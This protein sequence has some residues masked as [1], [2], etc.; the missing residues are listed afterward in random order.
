MGLGGRRRCRRGRLELT[1]GLE[2]SPQQRGALL[3]AHAAEYID[4][5][6]SFGSRGKSMTLP[7]APAF[8]SQAPNTTRDTRALSTAPMHI[9]HGSSVAYSVV[10]P[11]R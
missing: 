6:L 3:A 4:T 8:W 5:M 7:Q 9:A 2:E 10:P 1:A 11:S